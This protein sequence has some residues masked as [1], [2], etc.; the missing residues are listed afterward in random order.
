MRNSYLSLNSSVI[1]GTRVWVG[2]SRFV[3]RHGKEIF[4]FSKSQGRFR[5]TSRLLFGGYRGLFPRG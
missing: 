4:L 1:L 2:R 3:Y 5:G